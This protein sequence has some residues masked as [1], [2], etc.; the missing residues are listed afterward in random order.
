MRRTRLKLN[1]SKI[2]GQGM[3]EYIIITAL[4]S[5]AAIFVVTNFGSVI[6]AQFGHIASQ[7][8]GSTSKESIEKSKQSGEAARNEGV[9]KHSLADYG[10]K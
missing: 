2:F 1:R 5:V 3:T 10:A 6:K 8:A 4:V 7:L 9:K